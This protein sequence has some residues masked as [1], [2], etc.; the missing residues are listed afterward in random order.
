MQNRST[1]CKASLKCSLSLNIVCSTHICTCL[2]CNLILSTLIPLFTN[3]TVVPS[4]L[5]VP[6]AAFNLKIS[7]FKYPYTRVR[8]SEAGGCV[9]ALYSI[10]EAQLLLNRHWSFLWPSGKTWESWTVVSG[11]VL[12][13]FLSGHSNWCFILLLC[14]LS[15]QNHPCA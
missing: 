2:C 6:L 12:F 10:D 14:L 1:T 8:H 13:L 3:L 5:H 11:S 4:G 9:D 15:T 7:Y